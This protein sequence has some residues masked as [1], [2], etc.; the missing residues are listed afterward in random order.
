MNV[1]IKG[2]AILLLSCAALGLLPVARAGAAPFRP[3]EILF[4]E[5]ALMSRAVYR[6]DPATGAASY[7]APAVAPAGMALD[8]DGTLL[9]YDGFV[10]AFARYDAEG[11]GVGRFEPTFGGVPIFNLLGSTDFAV[12]PSGGVLF[13]ALLYDPES[14][15]QTV[16]LVRADPATGEVAPVTP[17]GVRTLALAPDGAVWGTGLNA[18]ADRLFR[19]DPATGARTLISAG[20]LF[21]SPIDLALQ[22]DGG[23]LV[24]DQEANALIRVDPITGTQRVVSSGGMFSYLTGVAVEPGGTILVSDAGLGALPGALLRVDPAT[25]A[26]TVLLGGLDTPV[27]VDVVPAV[28]PEPTA[29]ALALTSAALLLTRRGRRAPQ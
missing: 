1:C 11:N 10:A 6:V 19:I 17:V 25:G 20:G 24:A 26:Q 7:L 28:V 29:A 9:V 22:A 16:P 15:R 12:E 5:A 2:V 21:R 8:P 3:G 13:S 23:V 18:E 27:D 14:G 4:A